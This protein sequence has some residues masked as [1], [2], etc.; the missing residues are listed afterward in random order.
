MK[1]SLWLY[2]CELPKTAFLISLLWIAVPAHAQQNPFPVLTGKYVDKDEPSEEVTVFAKGII[3]TEGYEHSAPALSPDGK[4]VVW[5]IVERD[6]PSV[7]LEMRKVD[8]KWTRPQP[9]SFSAQTSDDMYP[10]FSADGRQLIF[11]SRR[12][13]PDGSAVNDIRLWVVN[14]TASGWGVP[15]PLDSTLSKGFEYAHS[16][17]EHGTIFFSARKVEDGKPKWNIYFSSR[18][19]GVY[20]EPKKLG[21]AINDGSYVD[22]PYISPDER[23]LIFESDRNGGM[24]SNDLY[25]CFKKSDGSWGDPKN[26]GPKV[27]SAFSERFAGLSPDGKCFFFSSNRNGA[28]PDIFWINADFIKALQ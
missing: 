18:L 15:A 12:P 28:L 10:A 6:K 9:V 13:L 27:N 16:V 20:R 17:S 22:G 3:S 1:K 21:P 24:G 8:G 26:M 5:G 7:L 14:A 25:I 4:T 23:F 19:N 11:G 2:A